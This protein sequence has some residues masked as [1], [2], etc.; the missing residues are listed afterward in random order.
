MER[1]S[2]VRDVAA[3]ADMLHEASI[4]MVRDTMSFDSRQ[5]ARLRD[6]ERRAQTEIK[7]KKRNWERQVEKMRLVNSFRF[8]RMI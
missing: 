8:Y 5:A 1:S 4:P 6:I 3:A 2:S 7:R